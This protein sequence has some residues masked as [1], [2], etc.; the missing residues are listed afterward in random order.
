MKRKLFM[1]ATAMMVLV[2][3]FASSSMVGAN[4][5]TNGGF[6]T[7]DLSG[8]TADSSWYVVDWNP[9]SGTYNATTQNWP[10]GWQ[11]ISQSIDT[12]AGQSY[13]VGFYLSNGDN[14]NDNEFVAQWNGDTKLQ[15]LNIDYS[16]LGAYTYYSYEAVA[17]GTSTVVAFGYRYNAQWFDLDDVSVNQVSAVPEPA[18]MLL[19]GFGLVGLAGLRRFKK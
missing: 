12:T 18:T 1:L 7:G 14:I 9:K 2:F 19:F 3:V 4:M 13:N 8:W 5:V 16:E 10:E 6:E 15:L 11:Y 17:T